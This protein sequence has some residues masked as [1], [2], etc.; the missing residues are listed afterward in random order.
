MSI[1]WWTL[2]SI[3][4]AISLFCLTD[5]I[6]WLL[7]IPLL[8]ATVVAGIK[9]VKLGYIIES[10]KVRRF[11]F[12]GILGFAF[13]WVLV[14]AGVYF[15]GWEIESKFDPVKLEEAKQKQRIR[16]LIEK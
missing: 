9:K 3:P 1:W 16:Y 15:F 2:W 5:P 14:A 10:P 4:L 8:V 13:L 7:G 6:G 11:V 12:W